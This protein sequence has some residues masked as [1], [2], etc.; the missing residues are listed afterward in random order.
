MWSISALCAWVGCSLKARMTATLFCPS[1]NTDLDLGGVFH[2]LDQSKDGCDALL[3][4][5][6]QES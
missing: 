2:R 1:L 4:T 3:S 5:A 6:E